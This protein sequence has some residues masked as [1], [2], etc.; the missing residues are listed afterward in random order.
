VSACLSQ[1]LRLV[2]CTI[3]HG[4]F[5]DEVFRRRAVVA[6]TLFNDAILRTALDNRLVVVDLRMI[7]HE[8]ADYANPIEPSSI[9]GAKI[10][11]AIVHAVTDSG[12]GGR[13]LRVVTV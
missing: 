12:P 6:L 11:R 1:N 2:V 8:R 4:N 9:G 3:Y 10:A 13:G 5:E 7:C